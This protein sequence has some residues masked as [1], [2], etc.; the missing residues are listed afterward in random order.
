MPMSAGIRKDTRHSHRHRD[1][2]DKQE[3][4]FEIYL[5][6]GNPGRLAN[7]VRTQLCNVEWVDTIREWIG[8]VCDAMREPSSSQR[9]ITRRSQHAVKARAVLLSPFI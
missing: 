3:T 1:V 7:K 4:L 8:V 6:T 5:K 9:T 2:R